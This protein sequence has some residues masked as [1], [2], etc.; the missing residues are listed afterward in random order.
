MPGVRALCLHQ[1][2]NT[3]STN[4]RVPHCQT[5]TNFTSLRHRLDDDE[6]LSDDHLEAAL[7]GVHFCLFFREPVSSLA[8]PTS[9]DG[10][11]I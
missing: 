3:I 8:A 6:T 1:K 9:C 10:P 2:I 11:Q 7:R 4:D 5:A